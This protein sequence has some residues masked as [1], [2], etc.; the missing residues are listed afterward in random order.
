M[1]KTTSE[2]Q[3][4]VRPATAT[5]EEGPWFY[6]LDKDGEIYDGYATMTEAIEEAEGCN[7]RLAIESSIEELDSTLDYLTESRKP[8]V[9]KALRQMIATAKTLADEE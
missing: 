9:L 3:Y 6:V 1:T 7:V 4:T 8:E 5:E 2:I